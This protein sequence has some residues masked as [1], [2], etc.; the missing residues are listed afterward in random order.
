VLHPNAKVL[1][2]ATAGAVQLWDI[3]TG[4]NLGSVSASCAAAVFTAGGDLVGIGR[5]GLLRFYRWLRR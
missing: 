1:A 2:D 4:A 5:T 3:E